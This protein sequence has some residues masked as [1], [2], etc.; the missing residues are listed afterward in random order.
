MFLNPKFA[1]FGR[2]AK[3]IGINTREPAKLG[4]AGTPLEVR[5][6]QMG[7]VEFGSSATKRKK[8]GTPKLWCAGIP[9]LRWGVA[10]P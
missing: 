9:P 2:P 8:K 6:L 7:G 5:C 1:E 3:D 10:D 4:S